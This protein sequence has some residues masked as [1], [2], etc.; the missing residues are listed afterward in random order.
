MQYCVYMSL[1]CDLI[2]RL[3]HLFTL[4]SWIFQTFNNNYSQVLDLWTEHR[5]T[6]KTRS[7]W[8]QEMHHWIKMGCSVLMVEIFQFFQWCSLRWRHVL[9]SVRPCVSCRGGW[10]VRILLRWIIACRRSHMQR[11][12]SHFSHVGDSALAQRSAGATRL[13][14]LQPVYVFQRAGLWKSPKE[15][16]GKGCIF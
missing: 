6:V 4:P 15:E 5:L 11:Q 8:M 9:T 10:A 16:D 2:S 3:H 14:A 13:L 1:I 7:T 12:S